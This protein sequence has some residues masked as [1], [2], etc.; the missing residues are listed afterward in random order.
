MRSWQFA[1]GSWLVHVNDIDHQFEYVANWQLVTGNCQLLSHLLADDFTQK[2][3][4]YLTALH[5]S[6]TRS[7]SYPF[8]KRNC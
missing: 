1:V 8:C 7:A 3:L 2:I 4:Y 5:N 6:R